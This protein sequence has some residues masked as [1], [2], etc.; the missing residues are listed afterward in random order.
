[1]NYLLGISIKSLHVPAQLFP[2][3][4]SKQINNARR[5]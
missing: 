2:F 3:V 1:M 4:F 5:I